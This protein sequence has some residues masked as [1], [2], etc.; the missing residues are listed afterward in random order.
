MAIVTGGRYFANG[1]SGKRGE[2][3]RAGA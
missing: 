2:L 3:H 1:G